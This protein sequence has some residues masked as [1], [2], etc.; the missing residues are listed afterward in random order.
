MIDGRWSTLGVQSVGRSLACRKISSGTTDSYEK[1]IEMAHHRILSMLRNLKIF[2]MFFASYLYY[3]TIAICSSNSLLL[4]IDNL[5]HAYDLCGFH[6]S[7]RRY[8]SVNPRGA[9]I[10]ST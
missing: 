3:N 8:I 9:F 4:P 10:P 2:V 7:H 1:A 6:H 5:S